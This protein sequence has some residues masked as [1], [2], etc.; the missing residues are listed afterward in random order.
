M[1][2]FSFIA[3]TSFLLNSKTKA[4]KPRKKE[5]NSRKFLSWTKYFPF[6]YP[7]LV[8]W[9]FGNLFLAWIPLTRDIRQYSRGNKANGLGAYTNENTLNWRINVI[10]MKGGGL[11]FSCNNEMLTV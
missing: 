8:P 10:F 11:R 1:N 7:P 4:T 5:R 6:E 3:V 9:E 2:N